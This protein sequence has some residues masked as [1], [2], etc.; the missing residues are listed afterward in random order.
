MPNPY[1]TCFVEAKYVETR[2]VYLLFLSKMFKMAHLVWIIYKHPLLSIARL[3]FKTTLPFW[4][5]SATPV[6]ETCMTCKWTTLWRNYTN[7][8]QGI[9]NPKT[10]NSRDVKYILLPIEATKINI[11][12][13]LIFTHD[14]F[15]LHYH[16]LVTTHTTH[17]TSLIQCNN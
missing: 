13:T 6:Y 11:K 14:F 9:I 15:I 2:N 8:Q 10:T 17:E 7:I 12:P 1:N 3:T 16:N 5:A 4:L